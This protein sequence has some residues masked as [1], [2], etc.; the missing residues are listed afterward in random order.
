MDMVKKIL[1]A[2]ALVIMG[3][4]AA[5][6][7][8]NAAGYSGGSVSFTGSFTAGGTANVHFSAG[9]FQ[10]SETVHVTVSGTGTI[11]FGVF[12]ADTISS[13][14]TASADGSLDVA[15]KLPAD[16]SG[17]Y[18]VTGTGATS[19][20]VVSGT[21]TVGTSGGGGGTSAG[22]SGLADTGSTV[23]ILAFWIAGGVVL[24]GAAFVAV[25]VVVRRQSRASA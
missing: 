8:A 19:G 17:T 20:S 18:P 4:F 10:G 11:T 14:K 13:D 5:P 2:L 9:S 6:L 25:R 23:S 1:A 21:F 24:L 3:F 7:A 12:K 16:A 22:G 15:V